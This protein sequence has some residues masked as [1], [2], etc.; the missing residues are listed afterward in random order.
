MGGGHLLAKTATHYALGSP[1]EVIHA[2]A[3]VLDIFG[4]SLRDKMHE[5]D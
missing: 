3:A 4:K 2:L 5:I 1:I